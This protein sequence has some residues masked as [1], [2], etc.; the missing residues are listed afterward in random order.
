MT[1]KARVAAF[2]REGKHSFK[3]WQELQKEIPEIRLKRVAKGPTL[4][5]VTEK[6]GFSDPETWL[7]NYEAGQKTHLSQALQQAREALVTEE[8]TK[9][10]KEEGF[11]VPTED[12]WY[13]QYADGYAE[14]VIRMANFVNDSFIKQNLDCSPENWKFGLKVRNVIFLLVTLIYQLP[15]NLSNKDEW[16]AEKFKELT[17]KLNKS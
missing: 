2:C 8:I 11:D 15:E 12:E 7:S 3:Q 17:T 13:R 6:E 16:T 14:A 10:L 9:I 1:L 4:I 5:C